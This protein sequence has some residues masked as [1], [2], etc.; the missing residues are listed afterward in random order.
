MITGREPPAVRLER[1]VAIIQT[2][3]QAPPPGSRPLP[4][5]EKAG[6][7]SAPGFVYFAYCAGRIKIGYTTDVGERM[8]GIATSSPF[9]VTLLLTIPGTPEDERSYHD[10]FGEDRTH[11]EWFDLSDDLREFLSANFGYGTHELLANAED[12]FEA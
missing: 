9:P 6:D 5:T 1:A 8:R 4:H 10:M 11:L 3:G 12:D 7:P 2:I